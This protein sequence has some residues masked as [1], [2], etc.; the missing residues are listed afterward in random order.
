MPNGD[1]QQFSGGGGLGAIATALGGQ[2]QLPLRERLEAH[3]KS[4]TV[5]HT[6][7][8]ELR[9]RVIGP[10]GSGGGPDKEDDDRPKVRATMN[11]LVQQA[12]ELSA[13]CSAMAMEVNTY[14]G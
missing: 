12:G 8:D 14:L 11:L 5:L 13:G 10:S 3:V 6:T 7:L 1:P 2:K 4:L 9:A